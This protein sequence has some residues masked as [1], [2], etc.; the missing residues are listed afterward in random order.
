[1]GLSQKLTIAMPRQVYMHYPFEREVQPLIKKTAF[2][3]RGF[4]KLW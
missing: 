1:M 4:G 2:D 3:S